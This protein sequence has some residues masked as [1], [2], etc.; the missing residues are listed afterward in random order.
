MHTVMIRQN[1]PKNWNDVRREVI[2]RLAF[3]R[4]HILIVSHDMISV[5]AVTAGRTHDSTKMYKTISDDV[6]IKL[7]VTYLARK[8]CDVITDSGR[9]ACNMPQK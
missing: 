3:N 7:D 5:H 1:S 2:S 4:F 9:L 8:N 6:Y